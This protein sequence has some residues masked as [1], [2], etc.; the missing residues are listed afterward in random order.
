[1]ALSHKARKRWA[2]VILLVWMPVY[3][4]LVVSLMSWLM[5]AGLRP[6]V[7]AEFL[8]YV[9]LGLLCFLPFRRVFLGI[10]QADPDAPPEDR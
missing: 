3:L 6:P 7:W 8:I 1:M 2:L 10:G 5:A 4:V 9:A